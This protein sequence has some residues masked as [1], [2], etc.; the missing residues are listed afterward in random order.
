MNVCTE[1]QGVLIPVLDDPTERES[2]KDETIVSFYLFTIVT[3]LLAAA[4]RSHLV[5]WWEVS[6]QKLLRRELRD[7]LAHR[8]AH[9]M[10][11]QEYQ[12][13]GAP[14]L[15]LAIKASIPGRDQIRGVS[16]G[17]VNR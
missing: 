13:G 6:N 5:V 7:N 9:H 3:L 2:G 1:D 4:L 15:L 11:P 12:T 17:W 14:A 16:R 10:R 8:L